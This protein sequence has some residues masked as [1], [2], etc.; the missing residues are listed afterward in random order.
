M[1]LTNT[2]FSIRSAS[3]STRKK[4]RIEWKIHTQIYCEILWTTKHLK[5]DSLIAD[6]FHLCAF[7]S[8]QKVNRFRRPQQNLNFFFFSSCVCFISASRKRV[9]LRER[10]VDAGWVMSTNFAIPYL[11]ALGCKS[12]GATLPPPDDDSRRRRK[13]VSDNFFLRPLDGLGS[14]RIVEIRRQINFDSLI[15]VFIIAIKSQE[16]EKTKG[17]NSSNIGRLDYVPVVG[18]PFCCAI[19]RSAA[20]TEMKINDGKLMIMSIKQPKH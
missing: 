7:L 1:L 11:A 5:G 12:P 19:H 16:R 15:Y 14:L 13:K 17:K 18:A 8:A 9:E 3:I 6:K 4:K 20:T 10:P 2:R